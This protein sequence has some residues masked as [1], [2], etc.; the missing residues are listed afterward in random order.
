[1]KLERYWS[2][3]WNGKY[4]AN[5]SDIKDTFQEDGVDYTIFSY[6]AVQ[7]RF[8]LTIPSECCSLIDNETTIEH[9]AQ[10]I[11]DALSNETDKPL[12]IFAFEGVNKGAI[13]SSTHQK[14]SKQ[15]ST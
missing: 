9:L 5:R 7:G 12:Q 1:M 13:A 10:H 14:S 4:L 2:D 11:C 15:T 8:E 6:D 3:H